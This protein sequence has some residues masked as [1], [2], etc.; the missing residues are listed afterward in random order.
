MENITVEE[1]V[2][3]LKHHLA[4]V[5]LLFASGTKLPLTS[6]ENQIGFLCTK[7]KKHQNLVA[8]V[9]LALFPWSSLQSSMTLVLY[10]MLNNKNEKKNMVATT[11]WILWI[12]CESD[13]S[14]NLVLI[15]GSIHGEHNRTF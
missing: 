9:A 10:Q 6:S 5:L 2:T 7:T 13:I 15:I 12:R 14:Y 1:H 3:F 8:L 4:S 11:E